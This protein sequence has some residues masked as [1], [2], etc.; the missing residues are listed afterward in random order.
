MGR[1]APDTTRPHN[2]GFRTDGVIYGGL[3]SRDQTDKMGCEVY[4]ASVGVSQPAMYIALC[5]FVSSPLIL[6]FS[7]TFDRYFHANAAPRVTPKL[8]CLRTA[9][10]LTSLVYLFTGTSLL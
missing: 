10:H 1:R 4:C 7:R 9:S 3:I 5:S 8:M 6:L 2:V